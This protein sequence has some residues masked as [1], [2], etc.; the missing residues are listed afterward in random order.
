MHSGKL[1]S[2]IEFVTILIHFARRKPL[3][4][5]ICPFFSFIIT[6]YYFWLIALLRRKKKDQ[7]SSEKDYLE[8]I[9]IVFRSVLKVFITE[10]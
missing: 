6:F 4:R 8:M 5:I 3:Q 9:H 1:K 2:E 10:Q 7:Q